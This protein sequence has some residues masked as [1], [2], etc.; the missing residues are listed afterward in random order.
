MFVKLSVFQLENNETQHD[1]IF[2]QVSQSTHTKS[3]KNPK[4]GTVHSEKCPL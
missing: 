1:V 3:F 2:L 4:C